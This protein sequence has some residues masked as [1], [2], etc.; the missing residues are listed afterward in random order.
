LNDLSV[1]V[2]EI[3]HLS[4]SYGHIRALDDFSLTIQKGEVVGILGPNGSGKTT[5]LGIL[6]DILKADKGDY[7]WFGQ[8][9]D[10]LTRRRIGALL[11][12]PIFYPYLSAVKNLQLVADIK[13]V[14]YNEIDEH[15][16]QVGL[17]ERRLGKF[18]TYSLGM[19]QRLAIAATLIGDPEVLILD[20]PTNGLDPKSIAEIRNLIID[21]AGRGLTVILASHLLDEVQKTC[22]HVAILD[23]GRSLHSGR[24]EDV[25]NSSTQLELR[26]QNMP[27]LL[28]ALAAFDFVAETRLD[29][30]MLTVSLNK[31]IDPAQLNRDLVSQG[32][33]LSHIMLRKRSLE[34][35]FLE[36]LSEK[37]G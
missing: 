26:T 8:K 25:L 14:G 13:G 33:Y 3:S 17:Y 11:E 15:L 2:L 23:K 6:L 37:N 27:E 19:K 35:Y 9:P 36:L 12:Q 1:P 4:K 20:E 31:E 22:S 10:S 21:I 18:K 28:K 29:K 5:T 7:R 24:V 16:K 32:I 30:D 34:S